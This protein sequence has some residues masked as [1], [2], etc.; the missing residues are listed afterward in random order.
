MLL[1]EL[2]I[3]AQVFISRLSRELLAMIIKF[4]HDVT[5]DA[6]YGHEFIFS[7]SLQCPVNTPS[8]A[9]TPLRWKTMSLLI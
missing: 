9:E 1:H 3:V 8:V 5:Y 2:V 6:A 4:L 7:L